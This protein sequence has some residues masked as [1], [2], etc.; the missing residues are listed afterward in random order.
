VNCGAIPD[1]LIESILF[2]DEKGAFTGAV[3]KHIGKFQEA[4]GGTLFLDEIGELRLDMQVKLLRAIQEGEVDP[5]GAKRPVK[6]DIR[7]IS[8]TNRN[9]QQ[10]VAEGKFREDLFYRLNVVRIHIP[11][12]RQRLEDIR[13]LAEHFLAKRTEGGRGR[14]MQFSREATEMLE[15]YHWP[16]NVRELENLI[17]RAVL[18]TNDDV[19]HGHHL[20]PTLQTA[21]ASN[22]PMGGTLDETL[23][24]VEREMI[25]EALK[26]A[27][28]NKAR[29]ARELGITE[30]L[31][32]LRV[33]KHDIQP[34][35]YK[36]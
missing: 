1:T 18:L 7:L 32:G 35:Q 6:V 8:A 17:Q 23:F 20:P 9:L 4:N 30:R 26:N 33:R 29:A 14:P 15:G 19:V 31:M 22:T 21:E 28:G 10:Q 36:V 27:R 34:R 5:V 3:D 2:G 25:I 12:L 24:R 11:P 13:L 16:G